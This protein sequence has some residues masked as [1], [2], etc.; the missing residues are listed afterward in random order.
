MAQ[1]SAA[2]Q[3]AQLPDPSQVHMIVQKFPWLSLSLCNLLHGDEGEV[4]GGVVDG[5]GVSK[6]V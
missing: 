2:Q 1:K 6:H 4:Q 5:K 3:A